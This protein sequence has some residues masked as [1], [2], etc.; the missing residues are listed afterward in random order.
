MEEDNDNWGDFYQIEAGDSEYDLGYALIEELYGN[1]LPP[2]LIKRYIDYDSLRQDLSTK[3]YDDDEITEMIKSDL[4]GIE[5]LKNYFDYEAF[6]RD[7][8]SKDGFEYRGNNL[9]ISPN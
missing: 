5:S 9:W 6:G 4:M 8:R 2:D 7:C 1:D 3:G